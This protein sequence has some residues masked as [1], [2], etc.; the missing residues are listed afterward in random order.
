MNSKEIKEINDEYV[1]GTYAPVLAIAEGQGAKVIDA[2]GNEFLDF[3]AGISV[4]NLGH[5]HP[6]VN[7]AAP[8]KS[9]RSIWV[10]RRP[11]R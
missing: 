11:S 6:T 1:L 2:D 9:L 4:C 3:V 5:C 7:A 8:W 10:R